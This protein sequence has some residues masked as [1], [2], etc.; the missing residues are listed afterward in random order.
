MGQGII[1]DKSGSVVCLSMCEPC[2]KIMN[3]TVTD[4]E[5]RPSVRVPQCEGM[6]RL[7]DVPRGP[8]EPSTYTQRP[9]AWVSER[10]GLPGMLLV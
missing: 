5:R 9:F 6:E 8:V 2:Y 7:D 4:P 10:S 1:N 3:I